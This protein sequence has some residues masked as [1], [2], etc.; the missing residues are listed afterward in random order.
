[1]ST[2]GAGGRAAVA[3]LG[4][5]A[6]WL[7]AGVLLGLGLARWVD[8]PMN[9][10]LGAGEEVGLQAGREIHRDAEG[11][12]TSRVPATHLLGREGVSRLRCMA[13]RGTCATTRT[14]EPC[15]VPPLQS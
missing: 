3:E 11:A 15:P 12:A 5:G 8:A 10:D 13:G 6:A 14:P 1:V 7:L 4:R 2:G 9:V